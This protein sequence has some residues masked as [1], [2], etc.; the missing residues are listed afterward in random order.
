MNC[1]TCGGCQIVG[2][3][4]CGRNG[5]F[6]TLWTGSIHADVDYKVH[7]PEGSRED[8]TK[9]LT[10]SGYAW[11]ADAGFVA[12]PHVSR[13]TGGVGIGWDVKVPVLGQKFRIKGRQ[14]DVQYV[15]RRERMWKMPRFLDDLLQS[16]STSVG[17]AQGAEAFSLARTAPVLDAVRNV[18]L[19]QDRSDEAVAADFEN[20]VTA[21][22][23]A[24]VR[25]HL[26]TARDRIARSSIRS[27]WNYAAVGLTVA[28]LAALA[29][30][31]FRGLLAA[32]D[33]AH[34]RTDPGG[35]AAFL[36]GVLLA[37][38]LGVT[39]LLAG[40]AGRSAVRT[41]LETKADR[42]PSQGA[43]PAIAA[44]ASIAVYVACASFI[45][46]GTST[47]AA[48]TG[49]APAVSSLPHVPPPTIPFVPSR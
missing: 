2:C 7:T 36:G 43:I 9:A 44:G 5:I 11:L 15:G 12:P 28:A 39:Y 3:A 49:P 16:L 46:S 45:G 20:A 25:I 29:S 42:L 41:V 19:H 14:Y 37:A 23:I 22:F 4:P 34:Q 6:T 8:W 24:G 17:S 38:L 21:D 27:V 35:G 1:T 26:E 31:Q 30:G 33:P 40:L 48:A 32:F 10:E 47:P 18:V 13:G